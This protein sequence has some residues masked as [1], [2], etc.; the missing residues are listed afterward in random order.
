MS[1]EPLKN[2]NAS[3]LRLKLYLG[4]LNQKYLELRADT[5]MYAMHSLRRGGV[6]AAWEAYVPRELLKVHG[7]W[8]SEA[9][10]AY[11]LAFQGALPQPGAGGPRDPDID[12]PRSESS[13]TQT[14]VLASRA[15][16]KPSAV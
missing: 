9:I 5:A 4:Q 13:W 3:A 12:V 15:Y 7:R 14:R 6:I 11:L 1:A 16:E 10:E 8:K 2:G